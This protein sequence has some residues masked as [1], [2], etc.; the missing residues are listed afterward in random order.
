[1]KLWSE[2]GLNRCD[3]FDKSSTSGNCLSKPIYRRITKKLGLLPVRQAGKQASTK[4][5]HNTNY[6]RDGNGNCLENDRLRFNP[7]NVNRSWDRAT[8]HG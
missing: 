5:K 8:N 1:M 7:C 6:T 4:Y 2:L 3:E